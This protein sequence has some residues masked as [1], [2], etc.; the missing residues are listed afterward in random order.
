[1]PAIKTF[2]YKDTEFTECNLIF[3]VPSVS[4]R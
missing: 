3:S 2:H 4:L 1:M